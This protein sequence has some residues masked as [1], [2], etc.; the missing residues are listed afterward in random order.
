[1]TCPSCS[2]AN[3]AGAAFCMKCGTRLAVDCSRCGA[4]L[5]SQAAFCMK[6]GHRV[7]EAV[8][9][10]SGDHG[11]LRKLIP[12]ELMAKLE[13]AARAGAM[14]GER[15]TVTMLFC[16]VEGSTTAAEHLDPEE[17]AEIMNGA[18]EHLIPPVY[19]YEGTLAR[20]MG[21]AILAFFGAPI[22]H[23]DDPERAVRAG[24]EILESIQP[25]RQGISRRWGV[26]FDVRVGINTGL[27]VV[28]AVGSDMR[29]EYTAMGDAVNVAARM[30]QTASPG[31]VQISES[32]RALVDKLF[33]FESLGAIDVKGRTEP[34][35]A[36]RVVRAIP[37]PDTIRGIE[38]L[39]APMVGR[40]GELERLRASLE[41]V[42]SGQ[43][44]IVSVQG[45]A[46]LGKSR[47]VTEAREAL[48]TDG[49][50]DR[51]RW[52][53]GRALSYETSVPLA[54][55]TRLVRRL[56]GVDDEA[57]GGSFWQAIE[58]MSRDLL[59]GTGADSAAFIGAVFGA[60]M[61]PE[62]ESRVSYLDPPKLR[63]EAF[64]ALEEMVGALAERGPVVAVF[65]DL[66]WA[67]SASID[68]AK[69]M[70]DLVETVPLGLILVFRPRRNEPSWEVHEAAARDHA[71]AYESIELAA[72]PDDDA[73]VLVSSLLSIDGLPDTVRE[74][75]LSRSEGNPFYLEEVIRSMIDHEVIVHDGE[76]WIATSEIVSM[77][78]PETLSSVITTRI[79]RL[80]ESAR[81]VVQAASVLGREFR[82]DELS[83]VLADHDVDSSLIELQ[84]RDI[85]IETARIP[86]RVFRFRHALMQ[87]A[88]YETVL[89]RR[90]TEIHALIADFLERIHPE[91]AET[92]AGH[93]LAARN[94]DRALPHVVEAGSRAL[95]AFAIPE[96]IDRFEQAL[97][98]L[99]TQT[100]PEPHGLRVTL[101]G[102]GRAREM[103]FDFE[104]AEAAYRRLRAEG[105]RRGDLAMALSGRNKAAFMTGMVFA[106]LDAALSELAS[107]EAAARS[108]DEG[109]GL[110]EACMYQCYL[111]TARG[112]FDDVEYYMTELARLGEESGD[113]E[114]ILF[115]M[116]HLANTLMYATEADRAI[117]RGEKALARAEEAGHLKFQA[118]VLTNALPFAYL[119]RDEIEAAMGC[120]ERGMEIATRIGDHTSVTLAAIVQG[121]L[122]MS[123][124]YYSEALA[125][126]RRAEA[127]ARSTGVPF[128]IT[129]GRC[130]IGTCYSSM[131]GAFREEVSQIH[132]ETLELAALPMGD[133]M[134]AWV[135]S[136]I[137]HCAI[138][139]GELDRAEE[140]FGLALDRRTVPMYMSRPEALS[141]MCDIAIERGDLESA[142]GWLAELR[143]Y[144]TSRSMRSAEVTLL[145]CEAEVAA[146]AGDHVRSL[147]HFD[148]ALE[149]LEGKG[150][151]RI[152]LDV[153]AA[154]IRSLVA[155]GNAEGERLARSDF[156]RTVG[157]IVGRIGDDALR[158]AFGQG[159]LDM[160]EAG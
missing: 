93:H 26:D 92:I 156:E 122:A 107:S 44:R 9:A 157:V 102:L 128:Y 21:D 109:S 6:C 28:G 38:G 57:G 59:P 141:G 116:V 88:V 138:A 43:G 68:L 86:K 80:D 75:I 24:L 130:V 61:P 127:A 98:I 133:L 67:D 158:V 134:G 139:A 29:V 50:I 131:G 83:A 113:V 2:E 74:S 110:A 144:V 150:F 19:H 13:S 82:Y 121:K 60:E 104:G 96:A 73:R 34:V 45:E 27:V 39:V 36:H 17:W 40:A 16:D 23:E 51:R 53:T 62:I 3:P 108:S 65:E 37:R 101:E 48:I 106:D 14:Q 20:L 105:E 56:V 5:P 114:T 149:R 63:M 137:G 15:R 78:V 87:E 70:L 95:A 4:E 148:E 154:R 118:E 147:G 140:L 112:E 151:A 22:G 129:L 124:G 35:E 135:W 76:K 54:S 100:E 89:L 160:I 31:T 72:L 47:L 90:R 126:F 97:A 132:T 81:R 79:D 58:S 18:F 123:Q 159:A 153:H 136:E 111:R 32:T 8:P 25:Y 77:R 115:G 117:E 146:A 120:V 33:E 42:A 91:R 125:L 143:T 10:S 155:L 30:E 49:A 69:Q 142:Q 119:Q 66:H 41:Q 84:R 7:A 152:E 71:H 145:M 52:V 55:A 85:L 64:R 1:M 94:P 11:D 46:G 12:R 99:D 103:R